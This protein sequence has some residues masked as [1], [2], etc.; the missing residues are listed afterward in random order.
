M[1]C[2]RVMH[3]RKDDRDIIIIID[4]CKHDYYV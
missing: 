2:G 1:E 3:C 4:D